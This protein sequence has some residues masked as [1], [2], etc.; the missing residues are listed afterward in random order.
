MRLS[1]VEG[2]VP[3]YA[4]GYTMHISANRDNILRRTDDLGLNVPNEQVAVLS[5]MLRMNPEPGSQN[6]EAFKH[7]FHRFGCFKLCPAVA[8]PNGVK[9]LPFSVLKKEMLFRHVSDIK[10]EDDMDGSILAK[11]HTKGKP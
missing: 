4:P 1:I 7:A 11:T 2:D 8:G 3:G 6:L 10:P 9:L 5:R